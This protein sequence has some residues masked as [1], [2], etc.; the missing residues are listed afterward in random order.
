[1]IKCLSKVDVMEHDLSK[2]SKK[3]DIISSELEKIPENPKVVERG[4]E[5]HKILSS[6]SSADLLKPFTI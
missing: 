3:L 1:M 5:L 4:E 6:L 2:Y